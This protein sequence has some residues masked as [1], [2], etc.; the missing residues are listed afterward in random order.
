[1]KPRSLEDENDGCNKQS[2]GTRAQVGGIVGSGEDALFAA[3]KK[4]ITH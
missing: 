3:W 4:T 1:M 2:D